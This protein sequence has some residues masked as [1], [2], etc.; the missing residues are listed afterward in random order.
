MKVAS[1]LGLLSDGGAVAVA[2][3]FSGTS[4]LEHS[5]SASSPGP[6]NTRKD[7][8]KERKESKAPPTD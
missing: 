6:N 8:R 4:N 3:L 2:V 1:F 7:G 5:L